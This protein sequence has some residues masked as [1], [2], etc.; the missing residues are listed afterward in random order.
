MKTIQKLALIFLLSGTAHAQAPE[1]SST[2]A[3]SAEECAALKEKM[4]PPIPPDVTPAA[5][6][7]IDMYSALAAIELV[8]RGCYGNLSPEKLSAAREQYHRSY[9]ASQYACS[10]LKTDG[11]RCV[12]QDHANTNFSELR[13][14]ENSAANVAGK[15]GGM[16]ARECEARKQA[17]ISTHVPDSASITESHETVMFMTKSVV[18]M[19]DGG[20]PAE[21]G[22]TPA[23]VSAERQL[24]QQQYADAENACNAVQSGGR[25]CV[26]QNHFGP[27]ST[28]GQVTSGTAKPA[29][30]EPPKRETFECKFDP[31]YVNGRTKEGYE[32]A[33]YDPVTSRMWCYSGSPS[34][35]SAPANGGQRSCGKNC[36][37]N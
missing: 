36:T 28:T 33:A 4:Y 24:R 20:C 23:Q 10:K 32:V 29:N 16:S 12:A 35:K 8:D 25:R 6:H 14:Q 1:A 2:A 19:I 37:T 30:P 7:E 31:D 5:R 11:T 9:L 26:A 22:V 21:P 34:N 27:G 18:D 3:A 13:R 17:I 15:N